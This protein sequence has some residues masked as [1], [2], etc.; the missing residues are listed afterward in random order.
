MGGGLN[1]GVGKEGKWGRA[2][3]TATYRV[4]AR[5]M[6]FWFP[7]SREPSLI[8]PFFFLGVLLGSRLRGTEEIGMPGGVLEGKRRA[9]G[10]REEQIGDL[11]TWWSGRS[12]AGVI[13]G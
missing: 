1:S 9:G 13:Y 6:S 12:Q 3:A 5:R 8:A 2:E 10:R 11:L 4:E 7:G